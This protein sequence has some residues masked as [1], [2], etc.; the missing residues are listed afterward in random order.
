MSRLHRAWVVLIFG[1]G[2]AQASTVAAP[3][4]IHWETHLDRA[5]A[6]SRETNKPVLVEFWATWCTVCKGMDE[7][8]YS[9]DAV[10][11]AMARVVPV[12]IDVDREPATARRYDVAD[13]PTLVLTDALGNEL[14]RFRGGLAR[15]RLLSLLHELP[16]DISRVN[17]LSGAIAAGGADTATLQSLAAEL[18]DAA[19]YVA[20][21]RYYERALRSTDAK[22]DPTIRGGI[23]VSIGR[24]DAA[25][26][27]F[28]E[29]A[30]S[31]GLA[32][33]ELRGGPSEPSV[34]LEL[35]RAQMSQGRVG[36]ARKTLQDLIGRFGGSAAA[37][38]AARLAATLRGR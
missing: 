12:R 35:A 10:A 33:R 18:R 8:V 22:R 34:I 4:E 30:R 9:D 3:V 11:A 31:F 29:A 36:D 23:L 7:D 17:R 38:E 26:Q 28:D 13:T 16:S 14:F 2:L 25:L 1:T 24:N 37:G 5:V 27:T 21:N 15:A 32:L 6:M 19:L 20:S